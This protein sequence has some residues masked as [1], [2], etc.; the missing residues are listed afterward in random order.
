[1]TFFSHEF[2]LFLLHATHRHAQLCF[3][4][5]RIVAC[6][7]HRLSKVDAGAERVL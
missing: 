4:V 6:A 7:L 2:I 5:Q 3:F 1:L